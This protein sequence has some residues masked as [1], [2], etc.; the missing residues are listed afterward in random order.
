MAAGVA[1]LRLRTNFPLAFD[2]RSGTLLFLQLFISHAL[3]F[4]E[5]AVM[6]RGLVTFALVL[7][8]A[9]AAAAA[10]APVSLLPVVLRC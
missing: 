5:Q 4:Y 7:L 9:A 6:P 10:A 1:A 3:R 2:L 8:A